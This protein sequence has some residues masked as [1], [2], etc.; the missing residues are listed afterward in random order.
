[1]KH[2][3][4]ALLLSFVALTAAAQTGS[5]AAASSQPPARQPIPATPGATFDLAWIG[6]IVRL[7]DPQI[8]PSGKSVALVATRPDYEHDLNLAE[9]YLVD[10]ST[11]AT[12]PL[13][14]NRKSAAFPALVAL[15]RNAR[16]PR[17]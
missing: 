3:A 17:R 8:S 10:T 7:T 14:H 11:G 6:K 4:A 16:L 9:I 1:M 12:R 13:T 2:L 5:P 15:R